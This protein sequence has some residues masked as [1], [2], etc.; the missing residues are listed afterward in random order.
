M[1]SPTLSVETFNTSVFNNILP[2][3]FLV[4]LYSV[5]S[6]NSSDDVIFDVQ[7]DPNNRLVR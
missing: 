3:I 5:V 7:G 4:M 6:N 2:G 1:G